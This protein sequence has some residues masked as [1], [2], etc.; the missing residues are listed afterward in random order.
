[1]PHPSS[2]ATR[3]APHAIWRG[4]NQTLKQDSMGGLLLL[5]ATIAALILANSPAAPWYENLR[6]FTFGPESL[7]LNLSVGAWA[8]DGL[9]AIFFFVVGL[10]L[11]EEFVVGKLRNPRT[12][13][14]PIA[15]AVGGVALPAVFYTLVITTS[16]SSAI[17]GWAIPAATDIAFAVAVIAVVG[18]FLPPALRTF[19]LT[20]AVVDD[21]LA[22]SIIAIFY[23]DDLAWLPLLIA[24]LPLALFTI[25]VQR[26]VRA[27]WILIP[28]GVSVWALVH[29]SGI[30]ATVAGVLLGFMVPVIASK[31]A[32]VNVGKN[33][34]GEPIYEGLAAHFADRWSIASSIIAI[35]IFAFFAAGVAIGGF[36]G[37]RESLLSPVA[38]GIIAGLILGKSIGITT[39]TFLVTKLPG[40]ELDRS[41][42][43]IDLLGMSFIAGIGFT[44]SLLVGELAFGAQGE[45]AQYV[46]VGVLCG[47]LL[48]AIIGALILG[49][50]NRTY[51]ALQ[52]DMK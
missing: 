23:T 42:K 8:A 11:K 39:A 9:L 47:S 5:C 13:L 17:N 22:I 36:A 33:K 30:H 38:L 43:W 49:A 46:K 21:L 35:P 52:A 40:I 19:L 51:R 45:E 20:L 14:V 44:V 1:M 18:K 32:R 2:D 4:I 3:Q 16:G 48:A 37:L 28:L 25:A 50:R 6:D 27:W 26:G 34:D 7:H 31:R 29:A 12:A 15:A 10:E 24:L 41:I